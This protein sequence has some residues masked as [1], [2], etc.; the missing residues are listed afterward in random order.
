M[1]KILSGGGFRKYDDTVKLNAV[2]SLIFEEFV[3]TGIETSFEHF[4]VNDVNYKNVVARIGS[5]DKPTIVIGAHCDVCGE[6]PG[7]DDNA[8][9]V[10]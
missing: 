5:M 10:V 1:E 3:K 7:A 9:G 6:T 4:R 2:A 8:S